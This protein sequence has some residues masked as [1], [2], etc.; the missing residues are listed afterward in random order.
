MSGSAV[1]DWQGKLVGI[2]VGGG[3]IF[4][5]EQIGVIIPV[6]HFKEILERSP[7]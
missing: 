7:E 6:N 3:S 5:K 1:Y 2:L 4:S